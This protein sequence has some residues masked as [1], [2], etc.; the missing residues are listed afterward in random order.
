V[1]SVAGI[2]DPGPTGVNDPGYNSAEAEQE[3]E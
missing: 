3:K 1:E 2:G